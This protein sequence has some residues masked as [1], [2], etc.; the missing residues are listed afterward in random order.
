MNYEP[1]LNIVT[2]TRTIII[3]THHKT[4]QQDNFEVSYVA[5]LY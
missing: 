5:K 2:L 1:W 3:D 4:I